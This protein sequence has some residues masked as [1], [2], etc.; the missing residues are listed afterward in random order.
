MAKAEDV[1]PI[2]RIA[3]TVLGIG[4]LGPGLINAMTVGGV[5]QVQL[6][7]TVARVDRTKMRSRGFNF[8]INGQTVSTG[9]ILGGIASSS[10][11]SGNNTVSTGVGIIPGAGSLLPTSSANLVFGVIPAQFQGLLQA[12][13]TEGLSKTIAEPKLITQSGRPA[14]FLSGGQQATLGPSSGI[15]GPGVVYQDIG[16]ELEFLPIVYGNGKIYLEVAPRV[17][18]VNTGLGVTTSFGTVPGFDDQSVRTS[19]V[20]EAGQ[21]FAIGGLIQTTVQA[22]AAKTPVLGEL[23]FIGPFFSTQTETET[24]SQEAGDSRHA[25]FGRSHGLQPSAKATARPRNAVARTT[26]NS[27]WRASSSCRAASAMFSRTSTTRAP[28]RTTRPPRLSRAVSA[29]EAM[30]I[31]ACGN[32]QLRRLPAIAPATPFLCRQRKRSRAPVSR[33]SCRRPCRRRWT[34]RFRPRNFGE[35][36]RDD[37]VKAAR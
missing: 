13:K 36:F 14:R 20:M 21:T 4:P 32:G 11:T 8:A 33:I 6:D 31:T 24:K 2:L 37:K 18:A 3:G 9:S 35:M 30:V 23:P 5:N 7:V 28:G 10:S 19:V 22:S 29:T 34:F 12:L 27:T 1:D 25:A 15:N 17:K 16:T 26:S